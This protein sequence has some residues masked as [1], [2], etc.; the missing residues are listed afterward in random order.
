MPLKALGPTPLAALYHTLEDGTA[1]VDP[2]GL[3]K[4]IAVTTRPC[5]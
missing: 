3:W 1:A 5:R 2:V 4:G